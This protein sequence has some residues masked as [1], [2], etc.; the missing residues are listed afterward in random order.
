MRAEV[1]KGERVSTV[2]DY[3]REPQADSSSGKAALVVQGGGMRGVYSMGALAAIEDAGL[4]H[5]FDVV[6]G[7]S[8]GAINGAYLLAGQAHEAVRV[9]IDLLSNRSFVNFARFWKV[10]DIDYLVDRALKVEMPIDLE[11]LRNSPTLLEVVL[12]DAETG[13]PAI[14]TN[15]DTDLDFYEVIRATAALPALYNGR[16]QL[17]DRTYVDGGVVDAVPVVRAVDT[18]ADRV[19]AVLTRSPDFRRVEKGLAF[20]LIAR[21][22]ARGQSHAV[23]SLLGRADSRFNAAM[24]LLQAAGGSAGHPEQWSVWPS[25]PDHLVS[26]TTF[27]KSKLQACADMGREDMATLLTACTTTTDEQQQGSW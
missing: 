17:R 3:L 18:G 26:R 4:R 12:T 8:A 13:Q 22:L 27:D 20:R 6:I 11:E 10:V 24:D 14:V 21:S 16:V 19:L 23:K 7:S 2:A 15:R 1:E 25:D 9:Y 5:A